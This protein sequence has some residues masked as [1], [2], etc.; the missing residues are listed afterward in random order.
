MLEPRYRKAPEASDHCS[1]AVVVVHPVEMSGDLN[2]YLDGRC[3]V[4]P[5]VENSERHPARDL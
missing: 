4:L 3:P 2:K 1:A 5:P